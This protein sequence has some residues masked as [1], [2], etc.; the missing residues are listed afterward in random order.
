[1]SWKDVK[2]EKII[3]VPEHDPAEL[4]KLPYFAYGS[5]LYGEQM[6]Q[7]CP[8]SKVKAPAILNGYKLVFREVAD[9][10]KRKHNKVVGML[11]KVTAPDIVA[12]NKCEGYP[13][14]YTITIGD[15][16]VGHRTIKCFWYE[17]KDK[18]THLSEAP[19]GIYFAKIAAGYAAWSLDPQELYGSI[20]RVQNAVK[21]RTRKKAKDELLN[22]P[23]VKAITTDELIEWLDERKQLGI[24]HQ[25]T[26]E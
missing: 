5:N 17:I 19:K 15:V 7:R 23:T 18:K 4:A 11:Y 12:L 9:I 21:A 6:R 22:P 14:K 10:T 26:I 16:M 1:M 25:K 20:R 8:F 3:I 13:Y 24:V 2:E